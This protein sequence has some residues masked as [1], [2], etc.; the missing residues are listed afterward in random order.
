MHIFHSKTSVGVTHRT[1]NDTY[2]K[3]IFELIFSPLINRIGP[4]S[5]YTNK[6]D[7]RCKQ[8]RRH[9]YP[10]TKFSLL[11]WVLQLLKL[12]AQRQHFDLTNTFLYHRIKLGFFCLFSQ[13]FSWQQPALT[14]S[15]FLGKYLQRKHSMSHWSSSNIDQLRSLKRTFKIRFISILGLMMTI[16][17]RE[18]S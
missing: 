9:D 11:Q 5:M 12:T 4:T 8:Q 15:S 17:I 16:V 10:H 7:M 2:S 6:L 13:L 3:K 18:S 1:F 14:A